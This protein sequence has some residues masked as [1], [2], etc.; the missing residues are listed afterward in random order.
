VSRSLDELEVRRFTAGE[1]V[2]AESA[3]ASAWQ[4]GLYV[5]VD[6]ELLVT[7][8]LADG[9]TERLATM[10]QGDFFG[11]L[12][13]VDDGPRSATVTAAT[14]AVVARLPAPA[15]DRLLA[16]APIIMRTI[17]A[18]LAGRLRA[19]DEARVM[20]RLN[21]ERL[22]L[23]GKTAAMLVHDLRN[24]IGAVV[25]FADLIIDGIGS[26]AT[27]A[28]RIKRATGF[29]SG[30]VDD[31]LAYAKGARSYELA[32]IAVREIIEDVEEFALMP[33]ERA[34]RI[35]V[36]RSVAGDGTINGDRRAL[37]RSLLN[38]VKNAADAMP[39]QGVLVFEVVTDAGAV[40]FA[41]SDT[42]GGIPAHVLPT[43]FEPFA[44][45]GKKGGTGLGLAM[46]KAAIDAHRGE[47]AVST[48]A[49]GTRFTVTLP[50][51]TV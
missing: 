20:A 4:S 12:P 36:R 5:V 32:P 31:L 16:E 11:E 19:A 46:T 50:L 22:S 41:I 15:V 2:L 34:G 14:G 8:A 10:T 29:M 6:G 30:M 45:H 51:A 18:T 13:L 39:G 25:G 17:A 35:D 43:L 48:G 33:L 26:P 47:I 40:R 3:P 49:D 42:G 44:T 9:K 37:S 28:G 24:P 27:Y 38:I 21:E 1:Q 7:R 23:I